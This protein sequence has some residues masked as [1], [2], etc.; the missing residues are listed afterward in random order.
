MVIFDIL[1]S[2][3]R[4]L[5]WHERAVESLLKETSDSHRTADLEN[6]AAQPSNG[7]HHN[8]ENGISQE[9]SSATETAAAL[10]DHAGP[11]PKLDSNQFRDDLPLDR[12]Y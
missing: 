10:A 7:P 12:R 2:H 3:H 4:M 8:A 11:R 9:R 5:L 6:N 1:A